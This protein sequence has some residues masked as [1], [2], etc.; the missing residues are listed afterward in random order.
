MKFSTLSPAL[1]GI[2]LLVSGSLL[3]HA[4]HASVS[5]TKGKTAIPHGNAT[6]DKDLTIQNDK[7]AFAIAVDSAPPWGVARGCIV[8][9]ANVKEDG[10]LSNDR[11]AF[12]DFI[13]NNWSSWPN[14][15]TK[16]DILKDTAKEA[17]VNIKRDFGETEVSTTYRLFEGSDLIRVE[18]TM[19][20]KGDSDL[21]LLSGY[22]LWPDSGYKFAVPSEK[23]KT[24]DA[25]E[26]SHASGD[27][28]AT[29]TQVTETQANKVWLADRFVGYGEDWAI[30]LHAPYM[31]EVKNQSR[32]LYTNTVLEPAQSVSFTGDY[33]VLP[34]G[35][36]APVVNAEIKRKNLDK[37]TLLGRVTTPDGNAV[38][39][40][41]IVVLKDDV[42]YMWALGNESETSEY[43]FNLPVG[44]YEIYATGKRHSDSKTH[45]VTIQKDVV[46][47]LSF[48]E[49]NA[50]GE[51]S[52][53]VSDI[54]TKGA[55]D[56]KIIIEK[57][58]QPL[59][60][61]LG[62]RTFFTELNEQGLATFALAPG[63]YLF[64]VSYGAGFNAKMDLKSVTVKANT[65]TNIASAIDVETYP[66]QHGWYAGDLHHH[67]NVLEGST[68]PNYLVRSQL[69]AGLNVLFVSDHDST[70]NNDYIQTL[71][72]KRGVPFIPSIEVSPSWGHFNA[73]PIDSGAQLRVDPG[74]DD[75]HAIIADIRR[76]GAT[77]IASNHPYI[78][79]GYLS[80]LEKGTAPGGFNPNIDLFELNAAVNNEPTI[81][82][83]HQFWNEGLPYYF[84]AGSD[85]HDVWN[86][87]SGL[88]R[89]FVYTGGKPN[90]KAFAQAAKDGHSYVSY[91]P[92]IYP[93]NVM[94]GDTMKLAKAQTQ[95]ISFDLVAVN[96]LKSVRLIGSDSTATTTA[97][98]KQRAVNS[99]VLENKTLTGD[100][101]SVSFEVPQA[102]GWVALVVEDNE[103]RKAYTNPIWLELVDESQ[104]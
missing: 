97:T 9:I 100:H 42:P 85:T 63:D 22:T 76:M 2:S 83:A 5:I 15:Y 60:E 71:A 12:A 103:D 88:N 45:Q 55:I 30:A 13:P 73:F 47:T 40:A 70:K 34:R 29:E 50:P 43:S 10:T 80:S 16:I 96:G 1:L 39:K 87:E 99:V 32:D 62:S 54:K 59:I 21:A 104:F 26:E 19:T 65:T 27:T 102:S 93:K 52:F 79:Y 17:A 36:L 44:N 101:E 89:L 77:V 28:H 81:N 68:S 95:T 61:Y 48:D 7:L 33:Q 84:T 53:N 82:K 8:D 86:Q 78:P 58:N 74:V 64:S 6:A 69:A 4:S 94:F 37:G 3:S 41:T 23:S 35:N 90:A 91:G 46:Q 56:A 75:I 38:E 11:V 67:A 66:T 25:M 18:T 51:V 20:N 31:T 98:N 72:D 92:V 49:L 14:T 57:G 24:T